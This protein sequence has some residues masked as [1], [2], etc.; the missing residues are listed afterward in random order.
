MT[1]TP[2]TAGEAREVAEYVDKWKSKGFSALCED[3]AK[4]LRVYADMLDR[5]APEDVGRDA[6]AIVLEVESA[7]GKQYLSASD[8][9]AYVDRI[10]ALMP[11]GAKPLEAAFLAGFMASGEGWNAEYPFDHLAEQIEADEG[12]QSALQSFLEAGQ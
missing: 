1:D 9:E 10:L 3:I 6:R 4:T 11:T 2:M 7:A 12:F 8:V 5:Q